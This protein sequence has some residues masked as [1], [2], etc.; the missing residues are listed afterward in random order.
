M[1][2]YLVQ[3]ILR[4][5]TKEPRPI[6]RLVEAPSEESARAIIRLN[7]EGYNKYEGGTI[8]D[9]LEVHEVLK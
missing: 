3:A 2:L 1:T 8:A 4:C 7:F 5:P 9:E 6:T